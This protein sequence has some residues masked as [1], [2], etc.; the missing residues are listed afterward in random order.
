[1]HHAL[2]C[3][4]FHQCL[5][6]YEMHC[7]RDEVHLYGSILPRVI[8]CSAE[9]VLVLAPLEQAAVL[10][11]ASLQRRGKAYADTMADWLTAPAVEAL[12]MQQLTTFA[13]AACTLLLRIRH[14]LERTRVRERGLL[15]LQAL[16]DFL[17][18]LINELNGVLCCQGFACIAGMAPVY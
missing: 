16:Y 18:V 4:V 1:M 9:K 12:L 13:V 6:G 11:H 5:D 2:Q 8:R 14:E 7:T 3:L 15:A 10:A 17:K